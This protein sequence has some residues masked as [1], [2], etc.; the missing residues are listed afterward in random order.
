MFGSVNAVTMFIETKHVEWTGLVRYELVI[1]W[2]TEI[3]TDEM[4]ALE[5]STADRKGLWVS[6]N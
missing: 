6:G 4:K 1:V 5:I 3:L 2:V